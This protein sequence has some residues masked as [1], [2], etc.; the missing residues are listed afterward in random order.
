MN[1]DEFLKAVKKAEL[2]S[3]KEWQVLLEKN[4]VLTRTPNVVLEPMKEMFTKG[5]KLGYIERLD[6]ET[7]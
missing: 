3:D 7:K 1:K 2:M 4:P 5:F 6:E